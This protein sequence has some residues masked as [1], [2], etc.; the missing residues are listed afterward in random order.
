M[1]CYIAESEVCDMLFDFIRTHETLQG[2]KD[3]CDGVSSAMLQNKGSEAIYHEKK[4][5][6]VTEK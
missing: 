6:L 4:H 3:D 5:T 2:N 1:E